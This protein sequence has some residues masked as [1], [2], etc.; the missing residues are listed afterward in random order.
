MS[1]TPSS[2]PSA[3]QLGLFLP[4]ARSHMPSVPT[5]YACWVGRVGR[6]LRPAERQP[7][8]M[9]LSGCGGLEEGRGRAQA[10]EL[11]LTR[12]RYLLCSSLIS[13]PSP[14]RTDAA[15]RRRGR[16]PQPD[17]ITVGGVVLD[18]AGPTGLHGEHHSF[19]A[20]DQPAPPR[21]QDD[22]RTDGALTCPQLWSSSTPQAH[23]LPLS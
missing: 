19:T 9:G 1:V 6:R 15:L 23:G 14:D 3:S 22:R 5:P 18:T 10:R 20:Q 4:G 12:L 8:W 16:S 7:H 13:L 17:A 11:Q 21:G 2:R